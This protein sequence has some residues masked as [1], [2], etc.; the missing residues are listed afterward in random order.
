ML[1]LSCARRRSCQ[2]AFGQGFDSPQLHHKSTVI[3]IEL[4]WAFSVPENRLESGFSA[5]SAHKQTPLQGNSAAGFCALYGFCGFFVV[6]IV[7]Q[8]G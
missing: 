5:V 6:V 8:L 3:L 2:S 4:R 1:K 7:K